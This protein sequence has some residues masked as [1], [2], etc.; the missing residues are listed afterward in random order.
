[1]RVSARTVATL[2]ALGF[3][4]LGLCARRAEG[5]DTVI[6]SRDARR[7]QTTGIEQWVVDVFNAPGTHRTF[8]ALTVDATARLDGDVA[9]LDGP[10]VVFGTITGDLVAINAHVTIAPGAVVERDVVVLGGT[11][12]IAEGARVEGS[13][14][15]HSERVAVRRVVDRLELVER[16]RVTHRWRGFDDRD[17][18]RAF[19]VLGIGRTYNRVEGLPLRLGAGA[20]WRAGATSGRIRGYGVFRTVGDFETN[21]ADIGYAVEG[22]LSLGTDAPRITLGA[23]GHDLVVPTQDWPL[24]LHEVGWAS[25]LWHRDY[26]D[27]FLQRGVAGFV[28]IEPAS[29]LTLTGEVARMEETSIA[30]RD[31]WTPS[32]N[33]E[34]WRSNPLVDQGDFTL[35]TGTLEYDSRPSERSWRSGTLLRATWEHAIGE[36]VVE[37]PLPV[38]IRPSLPAA[39][40]GFDRASVDLRRYQRI[41]WAGQLRL[42]GFWAGAVRGDPLPIQR[43][44]SLGGPDPMNGYAFRAFACN[45]GTNDPSLPGLC[46]HVVLFQAEYRGGFGF[47]W[48]DGDFGIRHHPDR[49]GRRDR[50]DRPDRPEGWKGGRDWD[51]GDWAWFDEPALV[52]FTNAG[53]GW[54]RSEDGPDKLHW[55]VGA[56]IAF[57]SVGL[58]VARAIQADEPFRVTLRIERRF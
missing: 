54:L 15:R 16:I 19:I 25:L 48:F 29:T 18:G 49:R 39:D 32:R 14:R 46:D 26:R 34:A 22:R 52:L 20:E 27:Y 21:R 6:V 33:D 50:P 36:N 9:V 38:S 2:L 35:L 40:Y 24:S 31:P 44:Y 55:D 45:E 58:Y 51:W 30:A 10:I 1:M 4:A 5:Q 47:D 57:G 17:R 13:T 23:R 11:L 53:A 12:E 3:L 42:R 7:Q 56:G 28:S 43:R 8:G 41:G 37:Q